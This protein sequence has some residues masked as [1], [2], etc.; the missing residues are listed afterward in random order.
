MRLLNTSTLPPCNMSRAAGGDD[1]FTFTDDNG[2]RWR[3]NAS[4]RPVRVQSLCY[5]ELT[6]TR[7]SKLEKA[8]QPAG[9][10]NVYDEEQARKVLGTDFRV[11]KIKSSEG[12][13]TMFH[14]TYTCGVKETKTEL[15]KNDFMRIIN[16][17]GTR[18]M[19]LNSHALKSPLRIPL[20]TPMEDWASEFVRHLPG[21][22]LILSG[23]DDVYADHKPRDTDG[24]YTLCKAGGENLNKPGLATQDAKC[25]EALLE[26]CKRQDPSY[27]PGNPL[28]EQLSSSIARPAS[29]TPSEIEDAKRQKRSERA[30]DARKEAEELVRDGVKTSGTKRSSAGY[31]PPSSSSKRAKTSA[32]PL[33]KRPF[34]EPSDSELVLGHL[35][36]T[37]TKRMDKKMASEDQVPASEKGPGYF[38][39]QYPSGVFQ[40][41][42]IPEHRPPSFG[43]AERQN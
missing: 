40:D 28:Q 35:P 25:P 31:L 43:R 27:E 16:P 20:D 32:E 30:Q 4:G 24:L 23:E 29:P 12:R 1:P 6:D 42:L 3:F 33:T 17:T 21:W 18:F 26:A 5:E 14:V 19:H 2:V 22:K 15:R 39:V 36:H 41:A 7:N 8:F 37:F 9:M 13:P 10:N 38:L 34:T 11:T